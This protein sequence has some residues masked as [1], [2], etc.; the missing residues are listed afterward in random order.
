MSTLRRR[1]QR[2]S[3][4][5]LRRAESERWG[6]LASSSRHRLL[7]Q[8]RAE[9]SLCRYD[10]RQLRANSSHLL[11]LLHRGRP[12]HAA[13][14]MQDSGSIL[15]TYAGSVRVMPYNV[16]GVAKAESRGQRALSPTTTARAAS[17]VNGLSADPVR[18]LAG[19]GIS[20]ARYMYSTSGVRRCGS[21]SASTKSAIR[22]SPAFRSLVRR[23]RRDPLCRF[24]LSCLDAD[25]RRVKRLDGGKGE[26][27]GSTSL[28]PN[29]PM[30]KGLSFTC[31]K[32]G[33]LLYSF[34][35]R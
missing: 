5:H 12:R 34:M 4:R 14:L 23:D 16:M 31:L 32:G 20:D 3:R 10:A 9:G 28:S 27:Q 35:K 1:G 13:A 26:P 24:R 17:R 29:L 30:Y 8:E 18:T 7:G 33:L 21:P 15:L 2:V 22:R 11:L 6:K 25:A 19:A